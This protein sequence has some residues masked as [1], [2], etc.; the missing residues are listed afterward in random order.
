MH[1]AKAETALSTIDVEQDFQVSFFPNPVKD[2]LHINSG[3]LKTMHYK[4]AIVDSNGKVVL[5]KEFKNPKLIESL[6]IAGLARGMYLV[7][8]QSE[9]KQINKKIVI[10]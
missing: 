1:F 10:E 7:Q 9:D 4:V 8:L 3:V 6:Q 5:E 2:S